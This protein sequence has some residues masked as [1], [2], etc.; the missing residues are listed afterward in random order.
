MAP[1]NHH[2]PTVAFPTGPATAPAANHPTNESTLADLQRIR[3][4][5][6]ALAAVA[7]T[8]WAGW[9][10]LATIRHQSTLERLIERQTLQYEQL[11]E[12]VRDLNATDPG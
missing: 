5:G 4:A 2:Q 1:P 7:I 10:S 9:I 11:R 8:G 6:W 3:W 12:A